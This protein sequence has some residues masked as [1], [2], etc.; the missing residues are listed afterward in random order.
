MTK[1]YDL[2]VQA[3]EYVMSCVDPML[4]MYVLFGVVIGVVCF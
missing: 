1:V 4:V 3:I 2:M